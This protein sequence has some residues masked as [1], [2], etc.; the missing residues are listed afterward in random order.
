MKV[1][2]GIVMWL[3]QER[4]L[5][6]SK[7][8]RLKGL[9]CNAMELFLYSNHRKD[10]SIMAKKKFKFKG[11]SIILA[12]IM[13][14]TSFP[15][16]AMAAPASDIPAEMLDNVYLDALAYTG[17]DVQAQ[18]ND[19]T[20]MKI[21]GSAVPASVRSDIG[22]GL[23]PS[24]LETV[25]N[26]STVS[27]K[28]PD[29]AKFEA[30][31][32]CCASYVS[33]VYYNYLP[34]VK[35]I[36]TSSAPCPTNPRSASGYNSA[37]NSWVSN[38]VA[39]RISFTQNS[40][41]SKFVPSEEIPIGSLIIFKHI[42]TGD[43]AHVAIYAG[44]YNGN[45]IV[46]H[47][48]NER[49]PEFSTIVGMSKGDYPEAVVQ[50]VVPEFVDAYGAI[51]VQ[52]NDTDGKGLAGAYFVATS[53]QDSSLQFLIGPTNSSGYAISNERIPYGKYTVKE[54]VFPANYRAYGQTEWTVTVNENNH[55]VA[56][57]TAVNE[58]IP[59]DVKI[60]KESEDG[61]IS[62]ITF[63]ITGNGVNKKVVTGRDGTIAVSLKPGT[64]T[65]T[66]EEYD[67]YVPQ[68]S[69]TVT[70]AS[71]GT[72][73]VNFN[74]KLRRGSLTV[75]KTSEDGLVE[76]AEFKLTGTS[77]S[78]HTVEMYACADESGIAKFEDVLIGTGY[79]LE[80]IGV[81][82]KYIIPEAQDVNIN[83]NEV[84]EKSVYNELKRGS[85]KVTKTS[86]DGLTEG[87]VFHLSGT[88]I[89]GIKVDEY[90]TANSDGVA[91]FEDILIGTGYVLTEENTASRYV[92]PDEQI[93][94]IEWNKVTEITVENILKKWRADVF[95][96][97]HELYFGRESLQKN[98]DA[99]VE[100]QGFPYGETQGNASLEGAI[101]GIYKDGVL[102]DTYTTD[103]NGYFITEYYPCGDD[104]T[105]TLREISPSEGYLLD[106]TVYYLDTDCENFTVE[107]NT[108]SP[109]VYE[110][111]I[112]G[113][114]AII[115]HSDDG[116]TQI[117]TPEENAKFQM[118]LA[119]SG[120][121]SESKETERAILV[122]DENGFAESPMMPYG[123]YVIKQIEGKPGTEFMPEFTVNISENNKTYRFLINNAGF[124]AY[125]RVVK[126]DSTTGKVIPYAGA[127]FQI[128]DPD[129][130]LVTMT[131][132]YPELTTID[133][134]YTSSDGT[135]LTPEKLPYGVG[136]S[137]VEVSA[138]YGYVLDS[139]PLYFNVAQGDSENE[140]GLTIINVNKKNDPQMGTIVIQKQGEVF[141]SVIEKDGIYTPIYETKGMKG[142]V[143]GV[144]A[145]ED[146]FTPDKTLRYS[147]GEKVAT[148]TTGSDGTATSKPLFLGKFEIREEQAPYGTILN[149]EPIYAE[150]TYAGETIE[151]TT[152]MVSVVNERQKVIISLL[153][154]LETDDQ[155]GIGLGSEYQN[156]KFGLYAAETLTAADGTEIPKD[157]LLDII[158]IDESGLGVFSADIPVGAKLYVKEYATDSHYLL[159]D[160]QYSV[161]FNYTDSSIASVQIDVNNG[162]AIENVIIRG[163]IKGVKT[164]E[165]N[166]TI[167]GAVF[168]LFK[169]GETDFTPENAL[170]TAVSDSEGLFAFDSVPYGSW[171]IKELSCPE[172][173]VL[174]DEPI[175]VTI[176]EQ[177]QLVELDVVNEIITGSVEGLKTDDKGTPIEGVIFGLFAPDTTEFT[178]ENALAL[179]ESTA[180][181]LFR[182]E[183]I[184]YGKYLIKELSCGEEFVMCEDVFEVDISENGQVIKIT[185]TNKRISGKVQV[186]KL[187][188]K[189]HSEKLSGAV[190]ELYL[191]VNKNGVFDVGTDTLY[192]KLSETE[193]GIYTLDGLGYNGYFLFESAAP[194]GFQKDDRYFYFK[195]KTD[196]ELITIENES[197]VGFVNEPVPESPDSPQTGDNSN[198][199]LWFLIACGSLGILI[200]ILFINKKKHITE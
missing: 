40:D 29:I 91:L 181:G 39:R 199:W 76:G 145:R 63:T 183:D 99:A 23:G 121:Y 72:A 173:L 48:G 89:S 177:D 131:Y 54:T 15:L 148:L 60:I 14:L 32:L 130:N 86:E 73:I 90:A 88:S 81:P 154:K 113:K 80:E 182:F 49:G 123:V 4:I 95:K 3:L 126:T 53:V 74:N 97:D 37:A 24:G 19:G 44:Y 27:G 174:S 47:V 41:G 108:I 105:W 122:C 147:A 34:N 20:I 28:A 164:D 110:H 127:G 132:T 171:L 189:D 8:P 140:D 75:T 150:L 31:G 179:S 5:D 138:P 46:T 175:P 128:Y 142:A 188:S 167:A 17:Y 170:A 9:H 184:R 136:Y 101:Y 120:S 30:N 162:K 82:E 6:K 125:L 178:E 13:V 161:E 16:T 55:G 172:H 84:T 77:L 36:D 135:L 92:I 98:S 50:V 51:E 163:N 168:G 100:E 78:G 107:L 155:Y 38:G 103:A 165:E 58:I 87:V 139:T 111:I 153:K 192:G 71:G 149:T 42:P 45:H 197:G 96:I 176:S 129:G 70:V 144:Y 43:I 83:W 102:V 33:Y 35:G 186:V 56:K 18:K 59:G 1:V 25:S 160:T 180:E 21:F 79:Q 143:F 68:K 137:L 22:Y 114:V 11:L 146:I 193:S 134:F 166:N 93:H 10:L 104:I 116:S 65:V 151:L 109:D 85:L 195:I 158:G 187:N 152:T 194:E 196:Y 169:P 115:K 118:Y 198:I 26:S 191:D 106:E 69:Q 185:V 159:S 61:N 112:K 141:S 62:G 133:T 117:E 64:Y 94:A 7:Y 157:G 200:T 119:S 52:K 66:E 57:F 2:C 12:L 156:I 124:N 190:F 67:T